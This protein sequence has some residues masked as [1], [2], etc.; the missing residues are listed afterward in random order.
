MIGILGSGF[1][2][3]GYLPAICQHYP[4]SK[5]LLKKS[6]KNKAYL[7]PE[8]KK[9]LNRITWIED[10]KEIIQKVELLVVSY[11]PFEVKKLS[12]LIVDSKTIKRVIIEKP[13]C[14]SPE[15][16][17]QFINQIENSGKK[18][19]SSFLFVYTDW[20]NLMKSGEN[21]KSIDWEIVNINSKD[22][23]KWNYKLGGGVLRFY[24]IHIIAVCALFN[25]KIQELSSN[26]SNNFQAVFANN[27]FI[28]NTHISY[29][30]NK[31]SFTLNDNFKYLSPFGTPSENIL[32][33]YRVPYL[34]K[35][36]EDLD[37]NYIFLN[38]LLKDTISLWREIEIFNSIK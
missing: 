6:A 26:N 2:L 32:E 24:G 3:Y 14:E 30:E 15:K 11:P 20:I 35:L 12:K 21:N 29:T 10:T 28:F 16:S 8:L 36:L 18:I 31:P 33:D 17:I 22:S 34:V 19:I 23:W 37:G 4:N 13:V 5:V 1:G 38:K 9:Y 27:N 25:C 7:R